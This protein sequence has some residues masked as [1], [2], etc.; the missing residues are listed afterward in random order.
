SNKAVLGVKF[1]PNGERVLVGTGGGEGYLWDIQGEKEVQSLRGHQGAV[2]GGAFSPHGQ[3]ALSGGGDKTRPVWDLEM[4]KE[5]ACFRQLNGPVTNVIFS[6][7]GR[8]AA[9]AD[10]AGNV[11][12]WRLPE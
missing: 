9:C 10:D 11:R 1:S 6:P 4:G 5:L 8:F 12:Q 2:Y 7:D 3:R